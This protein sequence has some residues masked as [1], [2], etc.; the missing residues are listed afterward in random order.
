MS[1]PYLRLST[2]ANSEMGLRMEKIN[3][4]SLIR[5]NSNLNEYNNKTTTFEKI[6]ALQSLLKEVTS[7]KERFENNKEK[8]E[9]QIKKNCY[10][11]YKSKISI[12]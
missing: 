8:M 12:Q 6:C 4:M 1:Q 9:I 11:Y 5:S 7:M 10:N 3:K 2:K